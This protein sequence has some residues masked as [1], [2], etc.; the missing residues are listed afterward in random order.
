M[1]ESISK[2]HAD[3]EE[4]VKYNY[5]TNVHK[6]NVPNIMN[7]QAHTHP[8][9]PMKGFRSIGSETDQCDCQLGTNIDS[10]I[11]STD[12]PLPYSTLYDERL[13]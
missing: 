8:T 7:G 6:S 1:E 5:A 13:T 12:Q 2:L 11:L 10:S 3:L 9:D 4:S